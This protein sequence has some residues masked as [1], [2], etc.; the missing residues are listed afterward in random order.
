MKIAW[1]YPLIIIGGMLQA[2]GAPMMPMK[3]C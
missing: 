3:T 1:I 2:V